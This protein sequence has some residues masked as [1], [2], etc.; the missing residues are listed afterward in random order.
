MSETPAGPVGVPVAVC[1]FSP[2]ASRAE[3]RETIARLAAEA[4]GR[5]ARLIVFPEYSSYFVDPMDASLADNAEGLDGDFVSTLT[6]LAADYGVVIVAG[7]VERAS[8]AAHVRNTVVAVRG[9]GILAVYRKQ[10]LYD[11]FGQTE[12]EWIEAGETGTAATFE[13]AGIRFG[14][15]TCYDLRFPEVSR[16][17]IDAG[18]DALVVPAEWVR[19]P[20]KEQHWTTLLAARAIENTAYVIGADHPTP[21][22][23]GHSQIVDPQGVVLAGVGTAEGI[24]VA[25][26]ERAVIDRVR[27]VNPSLRVRRYAVVPR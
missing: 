2:T 10:H 25:A 20:L 13:I 21:I 6:A 18:A 3:N 24:A 14:L 23:V 7:L 15:M 11:A 22:G 5:G 9:D 17:L 27:A 12:S 8:D 16:T 19:G 26:V 4:V 1:Q